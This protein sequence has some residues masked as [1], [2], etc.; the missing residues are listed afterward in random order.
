MKKSPIFCLNYNSSLLSLK[1]STNGSREQ[2]SLEKSNSSGD[3]KFV[4][5]VGEGNVINEMDRQQSLASITSTGMAVVKS[6]VSMSLI[7][8]KSSTFVMIYRLNLIIITLKH[9]NYLH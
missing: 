6:K 9:T 3:N 7:F 5:D 2:R 4:G 1:S 8:H